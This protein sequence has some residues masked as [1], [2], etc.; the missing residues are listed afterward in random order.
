MPI[1]GYRYDETLV[2]NP[3][4]LPCMRSQDQNS[5]QFLVLEFPLGFILNVYLKPKFEI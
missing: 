4:L 1:H 3:R 2:E 5:S